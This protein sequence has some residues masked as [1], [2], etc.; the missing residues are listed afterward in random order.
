VGYSHLNSRHQ[1]KRHTQIKVHGSVEDVDDLIDTAYPEN[2]SMSQKQIH[3]PPISSHS[4]MSLPPHTLIHA[5]LPTTVERKTSFN[6]PFKLD[7]NANSNFNNPFRSTSNENTNPNFAADLNLRKT[8]SMQVSE[9]NKNIQ[10]QQ[11]QPPI[12]L[13]SEDLDHLAMEFAS[14]IPTKNN[15][16]SGGDGQSH[17]EEDIYMSNPALV[18]RVSC[19]GNMGPQKQG[20]NTTYNNPFNNNKSC[21]NN[22]FAPKFL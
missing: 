10:Q 2:I 19:P 1:Q 9:P 17:D 15:L 5:D 8:V 14:K 18:N 22:P 4:D 3:L 12:C 6:N 11:V 21:R 16:L 13:S 20:F 7:Y